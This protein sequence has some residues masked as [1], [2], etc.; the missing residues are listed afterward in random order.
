MRRTHRKMYLLQ[1]YTAE[2]VYKPLMIAPITPHLF[3]TPQHC[4]LFPFLPTDV[5]HL[6]KVHQVCN[7]AQFSI[8]RAAILID[9]SFET[10]P[11]FFI[12]TIN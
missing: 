8:F 9:I 6:Q 10:V 7:Q 1:N 5:Q 11:T 12:I 4:D 2:V 3:V